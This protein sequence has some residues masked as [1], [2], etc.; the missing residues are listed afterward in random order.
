[1]SSDPRLN[2]VIVKGD[3]IETTKAIK[4][5]SI[6]K[7]TPDR[8]SMIPFPSKA[9]KLLI[10]EMQQ[11]MESKIGK[12]DD[13]SLHS[14]DDEWEDEAIDEYEELLDGIVFVNYCV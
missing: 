4:T 10:G 5:R 8:F 3:L 13:D 1:M 7:T 9:I 11:N 14:S 6:S 2:A 12:G